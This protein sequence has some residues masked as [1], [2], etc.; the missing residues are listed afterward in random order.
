MKNDLIMKIISEING[1]IVMHPRFN[2]A[3]KGILDIIIASEFS[4]IPFGATVIAPSG[5]GK[6]ALRLCIE[7]AIPSSTLLQDDV[8]SASVKAEAN[9]TVGH[10]ICNL[11]KQLG[12]PTT[13]RASTLYEQ[14]SLI[15]AALRERGVRVIFFDEFQH[16]C[17][18]KRTLSAAAITDWIK[19]IADE[20]GVVIVL[21][22]TREL[23]PLS[24]IND[25]LASR[26][27][28]HFELREF[29]RNEEWIGTLKQLAESVKSFD[30]SPIHT[31]F[32]KQLHI[33]TKGIMRSL[34]Q[35]L[36]ASAIAAVT[37]GKTSIDGT[38]LAIGY[39]R[40][41]GCDPHSPN[42]FINE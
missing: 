26:V 27:P 5:C 12:Y 32:H 41:F 3:Y 36:I 4:D 33:A 29:D 2:K 34:K 19:Q 40:V 35:I 20:A 8:R 15:A 11:M 23:K 31:Q 38:S 13:I 37:A 6:T 21:L 25:Q 24:E 18:G 9:S 17:R 16:I 22:G 39:T 7:R 10:L 28:A 1:T 14:S 42:V 30:F